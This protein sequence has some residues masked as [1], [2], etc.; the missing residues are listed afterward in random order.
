MNV[1]ELFVKLKLG[2]D[3]KN[4]AAVNKFR[5]GIVGLKER[6]E[7]FRKQAQAIAR[8][9]LP[10]FFRE[11]ESASTGLVGRFTDFIG[12][13]NIV[14]LAII[15]VVAALIKLTANAAEASEQLFK[16]SINTGMDTTALQKW[17]M[18]AEQAGVQAD[19]VADSFKSLQQKSI[20]I[21]LGRGDAGAFQMA[22]VNWFADAETQMNQIANMLKTRPKALGT[23]LGMDMGLSEEMITFLRMRDSLEPAAE[24]LILS[25]EEIAELKDFSIDF[26]ATWATFQRALQK[27]GVMILPIT[28]PFMQLGK[29]LMQI[30]IEIIS[31]INA[32]QARKYVI[33]GLITAIGLGLAL[34]FTP[35]TLSTV[36]IIAAIGAIL[37]AIEDFAAFMRGDDSLTG[38]MWESMKSGFKVAI[39]W[40]KQAWSDMLDWISTKANSIFETLFAPVKKLMEL[41]DQLGSPGEAAGKA[42]DKVKTSVPGEALGKAWEGV[43]GVF[44]TVA[45]AV[46][47]TPA[48]AGAAGGNAVMSQSIQIQIDGARDPKAVGDEVARRLKQE[49][50]NAV[51]Q[52]P[53]QEQ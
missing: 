31:W 5:Q 30:G 50:S 53:R 1:G 24:G 38:R 28:K 13:A 34:A 21:Q 17:Q 40:V 10:Q 35:L 6:A 39:D 4:A 46:G 43:K 14:R 12:K 41:K 19:E 32:V 27:L 18:Q 22:G 45:P 51:Y 8:E 11:S 47:P 52:M 36:L 37:L 44:S 23:K 25:P 3:G 15:G 49:T 48:M 9:K 29:G 16:F 42:W 7:D 2:E 33:M 26:K 20:D